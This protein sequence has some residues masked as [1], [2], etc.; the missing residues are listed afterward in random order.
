MSLKFSPE[1]SDA[2]LPLFLIK[3]R[4]V[5]FAGFHRMK[6]EVIT[7]QKPVVCFESCE[8][9]KQLTLF[10]YLEECLSECII[11]SKQ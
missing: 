6:C 2:M 9:W 8:I 1:F 10:I 4:Y 7:L 5:T 3:E 11:N